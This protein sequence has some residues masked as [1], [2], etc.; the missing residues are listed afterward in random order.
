MDIYLWEFECQNC[1]ETLLLDRE[2]AECCPYC[3]G[4]VDYSNGKIEIIAKYTPR[5]YRKD[6]EN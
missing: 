5:K 3:Q 4:S 1:G 6:E 2:K